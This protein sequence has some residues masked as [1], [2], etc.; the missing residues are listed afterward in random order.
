M[1]GIY[2]THLKACRDQVQGLEKGGQP[3]GGKGT[4]MELFYVF[5][6]EPGRE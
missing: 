1:D 4:E 6:R 3:Q 2:T 5:N